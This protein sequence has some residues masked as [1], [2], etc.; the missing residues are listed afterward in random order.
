VNR[1]NKTA[2]RNDPAFWLFVSFFSSAFILLLWATDDKTVRNISFLLLGTVFMVVILRFPLIGIAIIVASTPIVELLP[3]VS[4]ISSALIPLGGVTLFALIIYDRH[5]STT[6][7]SISSLEIFAVLYIL[8]VFLSNP[9]ASFYG[10]DRSW[11]LT[12]AQLLLL[13]WMAKRFVRS[14]KDHQLVMVIVTLGIVLSALVAVQEAGLGIELA[15]RAA[16]LSEG[17]N[18]AARYFVYGI[19][20]LSYLHSRLSEQPI[21]RLLT[22]AGIVLLTLASITTG[23][24]SGFLLLGLAFFFLTQHFLVGRQRSITLWLTLGMGF[25]WVLTQASGTILDPVHILDAILSGSDTVGARYDFWQ[26]GLAMW[27]DH[28]IAGIGIGRFRNYLLAYWQSYRPII[29][30]TP[31]NTYVQVLSE[32][33]AIGFILFVTL[34]STVFINFR[35]SI[36]TLPKNLSDIQWTWSIVLIILLVGSMTKTDLLDKFFWFL[37]GI[38]VNTYDL[39]QGATDAVFRQGVGQAYMEKQDENQG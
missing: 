34:L 22:L 37:M 35:S 20:L 12:F 17:A 1:I 19:I 5:R 13:M 25:F 21:K 27:L 39:R 24:R 14:E 7:S 36:K 6:K 38:S 3:Q 11:I 30:W 4:F 31:H 9:N 18:T 10:N 26:A 32:T 29:A 28:P 2:S 33:G 8:W 15:E 16:G 23:S